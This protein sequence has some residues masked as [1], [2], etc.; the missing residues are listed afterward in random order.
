MGGAAAAAVLLQEGRPPVGLL[1][2]LVAC[3]IAANLADTQVAAQIWFSG[4]FLA[5][6]LAAAFAGPI[7][8]FLVPVIG[9]LAT[10][11]VQHRRGFVILLNMGAAAAPTVLAAVV[12]Q[13]ATDPGT[14]AFYIL[15]VGLCW[16]VVAANFLIVPPL[17]AWLDSEPAIARLATFTDFVPS[18][19]VSIALTL[20]GAAVYVDLGATA[21][22]FAI[23]GI[24]SFSLSARL[25]SAARKRAR[26][27]AALSWGVLGG[28]LRAM[29][30]RD[31]RASRHAAAVAAYARDIAVASGMTPAEAELAH[32]AGLLH[33]IGRFALSDRVHDR[34]VGLTEADWA[35]IRT[36]PALGADMLRDLGAYGPVAEIVR[37]H[38]ERIDGL[39]YPDGLRAEDIPE[40]AKIVAVAEVYD[41]LTAGDTYRVP[42][43]SFEALQEL[44][45]VAGSQLDARY[46]ESLADALGGRALG[47]RH[48]AD[49]D[50]ERELDMERRIAEAAAT[51]PDHPI[52]P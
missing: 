37:A 14:A 23:A 24:V 48:A 42:L 10:W 18:V 34:G 4:A 30:A 33:D 52:H 41:T 19:A 29:D 8:A 9:E 50:F 17:M 7:G 46:V 40:I 35:S 38:H 11:P 26:Q 44:R 47:Y 3:A 28:L 16:A 49:A 39:G 31:P 45:R 12:L 21:A 1:V 13:H 5:G 25:A 32:T 51:L 15:L 2:L 6:M 22:G 36:H 20:A 43:S 27:H